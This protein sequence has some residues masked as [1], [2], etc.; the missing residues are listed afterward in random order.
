MG[1]EISQYEP[2]LAFDGGPF[3]ISLVRR[4]I[5]EAPDYL[6]SGGWLAFEVGKGQ[7]G[8]LR[9]S[10]AK[11]RNFTEVRAIRDQQDFIRVLL[12]CRQ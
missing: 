12:A 8:G 11:N 7:G 9:D 3:G 4:L 5:R 1:L 6:C 2:A 10:L